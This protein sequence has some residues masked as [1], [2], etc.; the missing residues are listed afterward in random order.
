M[1]VRIPC[2]ASAWL[3]CAFL[4]SST[5][6]S[7]SQLIVSDLGAANNGGAGTIGSDKWAAQGF[8]TPGLTYTLGSVTLR[9]AR[10]AITAATF[11]VSLWSATAG[12]IPGSQIAP[13]S[14]GNSIGVLS[15]S[16]SDLTFSAPGG[17]TLQPNTSYFLVLSASTPAPSGLIWGVTQAENPSS[18]GPGQVAGW[19]FS[20]NHGTT[21]GTI[22][23]NYTDG[24]VSLGNPFQFAVTAVPEPA[25]SA[26]VAGVVSLCFGLFRWRRLTGC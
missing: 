3:V 10:E 12:G 24:T 22:P 6:S 25:L 17:I 18:T 21:W 13:L 2:S 5:L 19:A 8:S 11:D 1:K 16:F 15:T 7:K 20:A 4:A 23:P 26:V 9:L 14:T